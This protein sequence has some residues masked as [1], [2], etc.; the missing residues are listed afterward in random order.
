MTFVCSWDAS[1]MYLRVLVL[2]FIQI[3]R[4][5]FNIMQEKKG[6]ILVR[7]LS[8]LKLGTTRSSKPQLEKKENQKS[9]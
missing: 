6:V 3:S 7:Q 8:M 9:G 2:L 4:L 5:A 1:K